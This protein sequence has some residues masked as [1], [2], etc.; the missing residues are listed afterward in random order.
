LPVLDPWPIVPSL[1]ALILPTTAIDVLHLQPIVYEVSSVPHLGK[2]LD[3]PMPPKWSPTTLG[4]VIKINLLWSLSK[5]TFS[6][7]VDAITSI[8]TTCA[9]IA[10]AQIISSLCN[11]FAILVLEGRPFNALLDFMSPAP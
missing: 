10:L 1:A 4:V 11:S 7:V 6:I 9:Y 2:A 3:I 8:A 5:A